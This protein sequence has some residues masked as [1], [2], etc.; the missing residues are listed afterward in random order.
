VWYWRQAI[1]G[2]LLAV[3][4]IA[5]SVTDECQMLPE[6]WYGKCRP[7]VW[8]V[9]PL[10]CGI[11][12][13]G[14]IGYNDS[15]CRRNWMQGKQDLH[16]AVMYKGKYETQLKYWL[17]IFANFRS[18]HRVDIYKGCGYSLIPARRHSTTAATTMMQTR[19][20]ANRTASTIVAVL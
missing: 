7:Q 13:C 8:A 11:N 12:L 3:A 15:K 17:L 6:K 19:M 5:F 14:T 20:I 2:M 10:L 9:A 16:A 18:E 4:E 1:T